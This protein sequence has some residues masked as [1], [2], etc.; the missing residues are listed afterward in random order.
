MNTDDNSRYVDLFT[1]LAATASRPGSPLALT[2][3]E[4]RNQRPGIVRRLAHALAGAR[5]RTGR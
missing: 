2:L 1:L 5:R 4:S 3:H